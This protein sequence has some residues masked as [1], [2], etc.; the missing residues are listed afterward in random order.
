MR[1]YTGHSGCGSDAG[2]S[3][4]D[5][6]VIRR[7]KSSPAICYFVNS[8]FI[9]PFYFC[10]IRELIISEFSCWLLFGKRALLALSGR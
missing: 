7:P 4:T 8:E 1:H 2:K 10:K 3:R 5:L 9:T 6:L